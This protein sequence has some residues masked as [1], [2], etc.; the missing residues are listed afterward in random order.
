MQSGRKLKS[1]YNSI[2]DSPKQKSMKSVGTIMS[3]RAI[4]NKGVARKDNHG[5]GPHR[6]L[7]YHNNN[8]LPDIVKRGPINKNKN[9]TIV[10]L[11]L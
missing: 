2:H 10:G 3:P 1:T 11:S 7:P 9:R 5:G 4:S 6:V 8:R